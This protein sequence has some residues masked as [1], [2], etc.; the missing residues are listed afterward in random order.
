MLHKILG[1]LLPDRL[2]KAARENDIRHMRNLIARGTDVN[3]LDKAGTTPLFHTADKGSVEAAKL[4]LDNGANINHAVP[5]GGMPLHSALFKQ[6]TELSLFLIDNG[7]DIRHPTVP[8]VTPLHMAV[9]GGMDVVAKRLLD[10]GADVHAL[11]AKGQSPLLFALLGLAMRKTDDP[12][13]LRLL[14][15]A[16]ADPRVGE[17]PESGMLAHLSGETVDVLREELEALAA[18]TRDAELRR[19]ALRSLEAMRQS[20]EE[21]AG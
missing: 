9:L 10:E 2:H 17:P 18:R 12:A 15:A 11:T 21:A 5:Q 20:L 7:A 19:Y 1:F 6:H 8:G 3:G 16:G 13:C 14:F 4:L